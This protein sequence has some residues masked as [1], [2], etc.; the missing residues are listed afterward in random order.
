LS[1]IVF[2][3]L[4][5]LGLDPIKVEFNILQSLSDNDISD[6]KDYISVMYENLELFKSALG[7]QAE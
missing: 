2:D 4:E 5:R 1:N 3:D 7:Y 6:G